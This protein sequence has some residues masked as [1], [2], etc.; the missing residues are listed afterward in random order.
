MRRREFIAL[1]GGTVAWPLAGSAQQS[2]RP[3]RVGVLLIITEN[4]P[5][6]KARTDALEIGLKERGWRKGRNLSVEYRW[7]GTSEA[8]RLQSYAAELASLNPDVLLAGGGPTV[9]PLQ[10]AAP[11]TP[12][13]FVLVSHQLLVSPLVP[14]VRFAACG[15]LRVR[16][17]PMPKRG[18]DWQTTALTR[19]A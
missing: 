7:A 16:R 1:V 13:V 18:N 6:A 5:Q 3:K 15:H 12:I 4:D 19:C 9:K 2:D 10:S 8:K 14:P 11:D 17:W